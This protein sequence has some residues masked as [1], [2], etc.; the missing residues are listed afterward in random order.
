ML[1]I[2]LPGANASKYK[3]IPII[4]RK[5]YGVG[6]KSLAHTVPAVWLLSLHLPTNEYDMCMVS[7]G[8]HEPEPFKYDPPASS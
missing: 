3:A 4:A 2:H 1:M 5:P 8:K 7:T 6:Q